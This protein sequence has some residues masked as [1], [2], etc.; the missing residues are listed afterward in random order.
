M[1]VWLRRLFRKSGQRYVV[2][3]KVKHKEI[4]CFSKV[5]QVLNYDNKWVY[6]VKSHGAKG[7]FFGPKS[8]FID[9]W[10]DWEIA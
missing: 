6:R 10:D 8:V 9:Y 2:G 3:E 4:G 7:S 5:I 1:F